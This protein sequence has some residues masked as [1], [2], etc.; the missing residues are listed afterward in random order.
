MFYR[1]IL[2]SA[3]LTLGVV[4]SATLPGLL[5]R[6]SSSGCS[7]TG[8][9]SCH[10]TTVQTNLC[11]FEAQ[12]WDTSGPGTALPQ[13]WT[14]HGLWPDNCDGSFEE[15]CDSSRD[16][17][18]ITQILESQGQTALLTFMQT[19]GNGKSNEFMSKVLAQH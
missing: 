7:T 9:V 18:N 10:N 17:T 2:L 13:N 3:A 6:A 16:Y 19:G 15:N 5:P 14:V 11:C 8:A 1:N 4:K 12:F